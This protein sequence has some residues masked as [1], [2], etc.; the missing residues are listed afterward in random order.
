MS[1]ADNVIADTL[2]IKAPALETMPFADWQQRAAAHTARAKELTAAHLARRA[3]AEKHPIE[4]FLY[5]YYSYKPAHLAKWHPGAGLLLEGCNN[6]ASWRYYSQDA[7]GA[8]VDLRKYFA[9]RSETV[10]Y[11]K[12]LLQLTQQHTPN[13]GCFGLHEWAMVYRLAPEEIR[14]RGLPLRL[15]IE[16]SNKVVEGHR[17]T[18]SHFDAFRFFTPGAAPLNTLQPTRDKQPQ[19]EQSACLHAG[20]DI[21]KWVIK[22][23]PII[24]GHILLAAF[25]LAR[26]IRY[27]D[28]QASPYDVSD[29][30]LSAIK[31]ET[32]TGKREYM[33]LQQEF[34]ARGNQL[35]QQVL[36]AITHAET[37]LGAA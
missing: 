36:T 22:L 23:G 18:C 27:V 32:A 12:N 5:T 35:R 17:I 3:R 4:D 16:G 29:Y 13:F 24:P 7:S 33:L 20:M 26:D 6:R 21:Y 28:M 37:L 19:L 34:A 15:G 30:G 25:E 10:R 2:Q 11:V 9:I 8:F 14:H 1:T 31:I